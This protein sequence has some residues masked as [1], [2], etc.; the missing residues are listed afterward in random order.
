[1]TMF[2]LMTVKAHKAI[3]EANKAIAEANK[4]LLRDIL[5]ERE[6]TKRL[7]ALVECRDAEIADL[8]PDAEWA[9]ARKEKAAEYEA[10]KRV[11]KAKG[12]A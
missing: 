4:G 2:G 12:A 10:S 3:A 8:R 6:K 1:M 9:R 5:A 11:R 7:A